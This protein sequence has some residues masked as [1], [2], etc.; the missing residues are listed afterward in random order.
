MNQNFAVMLDVSIH[1]NHVIQQN[2]VPVFSTS[3]FSAQNYMRHLPFARK[4]KTEKTTVMIKTETESK[5]GLH[6]FY[7]GRWSG[8]MCVVSFLW[9]T[10]R[11]PV[12]LF[13]GFPLSLQSQ[14]T[15]SNGNH[16]KNRSCTEHAD[17]TLCWKS[18]VEIWRIIRRVVSYFW[19]PFWE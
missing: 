8:L 5:W 19:S 4:L 10:S 15:S 12:S 14:S 3:S 1:P 9:L 13:V 7:C 6:L 17:L 2:V 18:D 11:N 16:R